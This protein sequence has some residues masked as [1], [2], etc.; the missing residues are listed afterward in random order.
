MSKKIVVVNQSSGYLMVDIANALTERYDKVALISGSLE[1][2][3]VQLDSTVER[4]KIIRYDRRNAI[5]RVLTWLVGFLQICWRLKR[6]KGFEVLYV[7]NPPISYFA[8]FFIKRPYSILIYDIYPDVLIN[9]GLTRNNWIY[10]QWGKI[11]RSVFANAKM[12]FTISEGMKRSLTN[13]VTDEKIKVIPIWTHL[14]RFGFVNKKENPFLKENGIQDKFIILYSG[15]MGYTHDVDI[16]VDVAEL[17]TNNKDV[18]FVFIGDGLK[19]KILQERVQKKDLSNCLFFPWQPIEH[20]HYSLSAGHI[21]FVSLN[22]RTALASVPSKTFN[23]MACGVPILA[24]SPKESELSNLLNIY[25]NG[26]NFECTDNLELI[27]RFIIELKDNPDIYAQMC[28]RSIEGARD[29]SV[30]NAQRFGA[31]LFEEQG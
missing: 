3:D 13:Y 20:I 1:I 26:R 5:Y 6:L 12:V 16:M 2:G 19:K 29:F 18:L 31:Y 11:N 10:R 4:Y 25:S 15:N 27:K 21:G 23:L 28:S 17:M 24:I 9:I 30:E 7:T 14:D 8:T 22:A